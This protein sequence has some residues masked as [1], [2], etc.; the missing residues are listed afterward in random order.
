MKDETA[1]C[2]EQDVT[3]AELE[4]LLRHRHSDPA[5]RAEVDQNLIGLALSGGGIRAATTA[6]GVLQALSKMGILPLVDYLSTVSGG[7]YMGGCFSSLLSW[8]G[9]V[10]DPSRPQDTDA[11]TFKEGDRPKFG[12][13][14]KD[15]PFRAAHAGRDGDGLSVVAHLRTHGNFLIA[16]MGLL[17]RETMRGLGAV[18]TGTA[19]HLAGF[20]LVLFAAAAVYMTLVTMIAPA[21]PA[22][23]RAQ[24]PVQPAA[25]APQSLVDT[26]STIVR[27]RTAS[28]LCDGQPCTEVVRTNRGMASL[29][30]RLVRNWNVARA[31]IASETGLLV[32]ALL[33]GAIIALIVLLLILLGLKAYVRGHWKPRA[34]DPGE[35]S[36]DFIERATLRTVAGLLFLTLALF[37]YRALRTSA[38]ADAEQLA[39]LFVPAAMCAGMSLVGFVLATAILP[40]FGSVWT[41]RMRSL[42]GATQTIQGYGV[43]IFLPFG[44]LPLVIYALDAYVVQVGWATLLSLLSARLLTRRASDNGKSRFKL[45]STLGKIVL[46]ILV[47]FIILGGFIFFAVLLVRANTTWLDFGTIALAVS[48]VVL[49]LGFLVDNNKVGLQSFYS[50]R[51]AETYLFTEKAGPDHR[52]GLFR[53]AMEMP[54]H[55]LHGDSKDPEWRNPAP[56]HL[57]SA[58]INL[59]GS[60]DLTR[61][62][63][64]SGYWLFSK[65]FVGSRHTGYRRT[66]RYREG[67][68]KLARAVSISGAA[69]SSGM[70]FHTFFAQAFATVLFNVRLGYWLR[71]PAHD[72]S[73]SMRENNVFWPYYLLREV[74]LNTTAT[75]GLVNISDGGHTGDNIGIYPLMQRRCKVIIAVDAEQDGALAF[76]S[77]TEALRHAYIDLGVDVDIDL[78]MLRPHP[79]TGLS[80]SH[81]AVGRIRY[82][83]RPEQESFL[84]YL[85]NSLT[86][87]EPA[88]LENYKARNPAF[89]HETTIDQFF[90][91]AQFEAYRALGVHIAEHTF[92]AWTNQYLFKIVETF[93]APRTGPLP[94]G[95]DPSKVL[96]AWMRL[97]ALHTSFSATENDEY[98]RLSDLLRDIE[99]SFMKDATLQEYYVDCMRAEGEAAAQKQVSDAPALDQVVMMQ[100]RLM[101]DAFYVLQLDQ[102]GNAPDN[103]GW[104][105]LMR[106]WGRSD[107]FNRSFDKVRTL[108]A[109][110]FV[111]FYDLYLKKYRDTVD[112]AP[113]PHPWDSPSRHQAFWD[114]RR[115][116]AG[117]NGAG[118]VGIFRDPGIRE[119]GEQPV[120]VPDARSQSA[121]EA[122]HAPATTPAPTQTGSAQT[123]APPGS[124]A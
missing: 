81:C 6:L 26:D 64:K 92:V 102:H 14:W 77:F 113:I 39:L 70:G 60:R 90:D 111:A 45:T 9:K 98:R 13:E 108:F 18:L 1:R 42:W 4:Y 116:E 112:D 83:D 62:D 65:L 80:R 110:E 17:T 118:A 36:E 43:V 96:D 30:D 74:L 35:T 63:R 89:P 61:K 10:A 25:L 7:G 86:G 119:A 75:S 72:A 79:V 44:L 5:A 11:Y 33:T 121:H 99:S 15:F 123:S 20:A 105:N 16:R 76:G 8:N 34:H 109:E 104:M 94:K 58:A 91:D 27:E 46:A 117:F 57:I 51:L 56:Y 122:Q 3:A 49:L 41:R 114:A 69:A 101:E 12:T 50:D 31:G 2:D 115:K 66:H 100:A 78:T 120:D 88:P 24:Q 28:V 85:K 52:L 21:T 95:F 73:V 37:L 59:A 22:V 67:R 29:G 107:A 103:R 97:Q 19:M 53:D 54:L 124:N 47:A 71:N 23:L 82:P 38:L 55:A 48:S 32:C 106:R 84:I 93:H 68:T 87:D 40:H